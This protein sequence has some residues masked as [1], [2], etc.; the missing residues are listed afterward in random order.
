MSIGNPFG[1]GAGPAHQVDRLL[2]ESYHV[3]KAVSDRL[4]SLGNVL[5]AADEFAQIKT[6]IQDKLDR[7]I[8]V[9]DAPYNAVGDGVTDDSAKIQAAIDAN[10]GGT[11]VLPAGKIFLAAGIVLS[12]ATYNGTT[13]IVLGT[14]KLKA[15]GGVPNQSD[16]PVFT[17]FRIHDCERITIDAPGM[18]D[19]NRTAQSAWQQHHLIT[20]TGA[21]NLVF[22]YLRAKEIRGD[23]IVTTTKT[24]VVPFLEADQTK[25]V[26]IG[27]IDVRNIEDD[28]RNAISIVS[29]DD[30]T[31]GQIISKKV[32]GII[33]NSSLGVL[34]R[35]PGGFNIE[36]DGPAHRQRRIRV[37]SVIVETIGTSGVCVIGYSMTNNPAARDWTAQD[38]EI[39]SFSVTHTG[40][41]IGGPIVLRAKDVSLY[42]TLRRTQTTTRLAGV[43]FDYADRINAILTVFGCSNALT[44]GF[45]DYV[46]D[47][48]ITIS[49]PDRIVALV[50]SGVNRTV[51]RGNA[52]KGQ[53]AGSY[54]ILISAA[55]G[56]T[57]LTQNGVTYSVDIPADVS[58]TSH[59]V[60]ARPD[61]TFIDCAITN[62]SFAGYPSSQ[63]QVRL[64]SFLPT[65]NVHGRSDAATQPT[66]GAYTKGDY[67]AAKSPIITSGKVLMGW[68]RLTDGNAHV[69]GTDWTP[70]YVPVAAA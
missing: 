32:G 27:T 11:I 50:A 26:V 23:V 51:F 14:F 8:Y 16:V 10:K 28:G 19:G 29:G 25:G 34:E 55:E 21:R 56:R 45:A 70:L 43:S 36:G 63:T 12:G 9:T 66:L 61:V 6:D 20:V 53:G 39:S 35:M 69:A 62:C 13:I 22:P 65:R 57:G 33:F 60:Y 49:A 58:G 1:S 52:G 17:G 64:D 59:G 41:E 7:I 54:G 46:N 18:L 47:S 42:G 38:I 3:V 40:D 15:S 24:N 37:G 31:I 48:D 68:L 30:I 67:V 44:C 2:G 5:E 4:D